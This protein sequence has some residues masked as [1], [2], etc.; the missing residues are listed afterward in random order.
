MKVVTEQKQR[1][2]WD[3]KVK[4]WGLLRVNQYFFD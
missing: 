3:T 1:L 4:K 2:L